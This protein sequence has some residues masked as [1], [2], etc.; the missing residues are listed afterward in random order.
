MLA[1]MAASPITTIWAWG[2]SVPPTA[3]A[4]GDGYADMTPAGVIGFAQAHS[5]T[6]VYLSVPWAADQGGP[7]QDWLLAT[8]TGLQATGVRV[9]AL[10][11]DRSWVAEPAL[12]VWWSRAALASAPFDGLQFDLEPWVAGT[13]P[14]VYAPQLAALYALVRSSVSLGSGALLA[15]APWWWAV[16]PTGGPGSPTVL[17]LTL[18]QLDGIAVV[19]FADHAN[20]S[21]G[22]I[23]LAQPA[24]TAA[25]GAGKPFTI[26]VETD[27][28]EVAGGA[29]YTF[30][31]EGSAVLEAEAGLVHDA[32]V[33][34]PGYSGVA[35]EHLRSWRVLKA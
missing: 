22:I 33:D 18:P 11:G 35:V 20:G 19:A 27:T 32:F 25:S 6:T 8:V 21:D 1:T 23:A 31:D 4:R 13:A 5:L 14:S 9:L 24:A 17:D 29:Q 3:D 34:L 16:T 10:G 15:D 2:N 12:A 26:G 30:F 7:I 28:P